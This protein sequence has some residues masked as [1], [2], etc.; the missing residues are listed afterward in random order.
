MDN[1]DRNSNLNEDMVDHNVLNSEPE[2]EQDNNPKCN[3]KDEG[4]ENASKV[5]EEQTLEALKHQLEEKTKQC[6]CYFDRL[7]R[8]AAEFDNY[9]KRTLKEKEA[10]YYEAIGDVVLSFLP[11]VDNLER[12]LKA[13]CK[14]DDKQTLR[15]GIELVVRQFKDA[16]KNLGVEEIKSVGEKFDPQFHEAVMHAHDET[17]EKNIIVEEF[18]KGYILKDRVIRHSMVKVLN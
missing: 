14:E 15:D 13:S 7:Q 17:Q 9:K 4:K 8:T 1:M 3:E 10:L 2:S 5:S 11:A 6:D 12:A 18:Q 16:L